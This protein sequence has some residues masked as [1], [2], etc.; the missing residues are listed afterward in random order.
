MW[1]FD[2]SCIVDKPPNYYLAMLTSHYIGTKPTLPELLKFMCTDGRV[3]NIP[4]EIADKSI[5][6]GTFLL[7]DKHGTR[8]KI[9]AYECLNNARQINIEIF[10]EWLTK[11]G[12]QPVT[13]ETLVEVLRDI[14]LFTL[15][16]KIEAVKCPA[17]K[18]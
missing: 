11:R 13:W 3:L 4:E 7:E 12:R 5:H 2:C 14:E 18:F 9:M 16:G 6:F 10:Q 17:R 8:V 15:A 1:F